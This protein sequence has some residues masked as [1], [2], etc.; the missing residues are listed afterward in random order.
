MHCT[1]GQPIAPDIKLL[2]Q[3]QAS[4]TRLP[5]SEKFMLPPLVRL[6][7]HPAFVEVA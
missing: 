1:A 5:G 4:K 2:K 6:L 3:L 7:G